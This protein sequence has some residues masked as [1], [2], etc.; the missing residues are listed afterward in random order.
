MTSPICRPTLPALTRAM[1]N[2]VRRCNELGRDIYDA[3]Q[4]KLATTP[5]SYCSDITTNK[6]KKDKFYGL[7]VV[8]VEDDVMVGKCAACRAQ[9]QTCNAYCKS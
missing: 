6:K 9:G 4:S 5:C 7:C 3:L 1:G 8:W 2:T